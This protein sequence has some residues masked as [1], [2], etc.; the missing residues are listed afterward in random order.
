MEKTTYV[1][2][3]NFI[4]STLARFRSN[5]LFL[6]F[7]RIASNA[8]FFIKKRAIFA[9]LFLTLGAY[10]NYD[11]KCVFHIFLEETKLK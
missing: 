1:S 3:P 4:R 6:F 10:V 9:V 2:Y 8:H 11:E 5:F 7:A